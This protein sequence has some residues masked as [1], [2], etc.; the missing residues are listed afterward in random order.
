MPTL[1]A[2]TNYFAKAILDHVVGK[3]EYIPPETLYLALF[4]V[5]PGKTGTDGTEVT[6]G[7]YER[8]PVVFADVTVT[9]TV[10][11]IAAIV[12]PDVLSSWG[13]VGGCA[14]MDSLTGGNMLYRGEMERPDPD[15][16]GA[17]IPQA[18]IPAVGDVFIVKAHQLVIAEK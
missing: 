18:T 5:D 8:Q 9:G 10:S 17:Y 12:F 11:N 2:K 16:I 14:V 1:A 6:G 3:A 15:N 4:D 13:S 7:G